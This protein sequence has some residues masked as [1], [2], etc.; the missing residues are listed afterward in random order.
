[1][2]TFSRGHSTL[3]FHGIVRTPFRQ[4]VFNECQLIKKNALKSIFP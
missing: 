4:K 2:S 3:F 1:M